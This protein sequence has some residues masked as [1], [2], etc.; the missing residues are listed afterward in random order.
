MLGDDEVWVYLHELPQFDYIGR[1]SQSSSRPSH[2]T[3][4]I[5]LMFVACFASISKESRVMRWRCYLCVCLTFTFSTSWLTFMKLWCNAIRSHPHL[6][7]HYNFLQSIMRKWWGHK[8][9]IWGVIYFCFIWIIGARYIEMHT[10]CVAS[11]G[12][13]TCQ[14]HSLVN[15]AW[16][17]SVKVGNGKVVTVLN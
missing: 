14:W 8:L 15:V 11:E 10:H 5:F 9:V 6:C 13:E 7:I 17:D 16:T 12:L 1:V 4:K 3:G 2:E